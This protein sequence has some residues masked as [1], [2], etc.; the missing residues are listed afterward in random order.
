MGKNIELCGIS[1][2]LLGLQK[3]MEQIQQVNSAV[4]LQNSMGLAEHMTQPFASL[5][6]NSAVSLQNSMGLAEH[7]TQPF[8]S[9]NLNSAFAVHGSSISSHF[10][11]IQD[12]INTINSATDICALSSFIGKIT[13]TFAPNIIGAELAYS[14]PLADQL[15]EIC[16]STRLSK[17]AFEAIQDIGLHQLAL[18]EFKEFVDNDVKSFKEKQKPI[19]LQQ[20]KGNKHTRKQ[21]IAKT[22]KLIK[23]KEI[24]CKLSFYVAIYGF[25]CQL[26]PCKNSFSEYSKYIYLAIVSLIAWFAQQKNDADEN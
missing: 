11:G 13:A 12:I 25:L 23:N 9:L 5:N 18:E 10:E 6:L 21:L 3:N 2:T 4:S 16:K 22:R 1:T 19:K 7:M 14:S 15:A 20:I 26:D 8:A 24:Q 17:N